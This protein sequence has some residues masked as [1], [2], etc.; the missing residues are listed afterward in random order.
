L[1][2]L[3]S[4]WYRITLCYLAL[5][6]VLANIFMLSAQCQKWLPGT[7]GNDIDNFRHHSHFAADVNAHDTTYYLAKASYY[8]DADTNNIFHTISLNSITFTAYYSHA[9]SFIISL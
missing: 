3:L 4:I 9:S 6:S 5:W 7:V 8:F 2:Y 1:I